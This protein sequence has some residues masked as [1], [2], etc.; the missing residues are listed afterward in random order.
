MSRTN[1]AHFDAAA[2]AVVI[3]E[4]AVSDKD[5]IRE[6]QRWTTGERGPIIDDPV[7]LAGADL[8]SFVTEA[9]RIDAHALSVTGQAQEARA[10]EQMLRALG[11]IT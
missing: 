5:V 3:E 4:L 9:I 8:S 7:E 10:L 6:A 11:E 1:A 2:S